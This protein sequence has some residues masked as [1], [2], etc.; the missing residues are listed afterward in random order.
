MIAVG[1]RVD[2]ARG[3]GSHH[4]GVL[5]LADRRGIEGRHPVATESEQPREPDDGDLGAGKPVD[6]CDHVPFEFRG[7]GDAGVLEELGDPGVV[8]GRHVGRESYDL[9]ADQR[10]HAPGLGRLPELPQAARQEAGLEDVAL[11]EGDVDRLQRTG[12]GGLEDQAAHRMVGQT[13]ADPRPG[14]AVST[15]QDEAGL[16]RRLRRALTEALL[17]CGHL[18]GP[19]GRDRPERGLLGGRQGGEV[20]VAY[21]VEGVAGRDRP[22]RALD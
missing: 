15:L 21:V 2:V 5:Q 17:R 16:D 14:T 12:P 9:G 3:D 4:A 6:V 10:K 20:S 19:Q 8:A 1:R 11:H 22:I 18:Q 7:R 13:Q